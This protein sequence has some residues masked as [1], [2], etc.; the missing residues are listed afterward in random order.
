LDQARFLQSFHSPD[1]QRR[2]SADV[3]SA[4]AAHVEG[5]PT[6]FLNGRR[7]DVSE[8]TAQALQN[9]IDAELQRNR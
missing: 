8:A 7:L 5:T 3:A 9:A 2:I 1:V 6:F 4:K